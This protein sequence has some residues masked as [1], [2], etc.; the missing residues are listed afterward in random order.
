MYVNSN[1]DLLPCNY[2]DGLKKRFYIICPKCY[3]KINKKVEM[4]L[5]E[6]I[7]MAVW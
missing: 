2:Y 7:V 3:P 1:V 6:L 5:V 4:E